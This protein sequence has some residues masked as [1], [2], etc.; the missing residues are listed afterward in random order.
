MGLK[1]PEPGL[2]LGN[3]GQ[4]G[5]EMKKNGMLMAKVFEK[6]AKEYGETFGYHSGRDFFVV[7]KNLDLI[8]SVLVKRFDCFT[9]RMKM[10]LISP[11]MSD[12]LLVA[13][14]IKWKYM[15][16]TLSP[17]FT[18]GKIKKMTATVCHKIDDV[19]KQLEKHAERGDCFDIF[20][21]YKGMTLD[22][23]AKVA[24]G[25]D[26][27]CIGDPKDS[28][29]AHT[30]EFFK[31]MPSPS[32]NPSMMLGVLFPEIGPLCSFW[33]SKTAKQG[34]AEAWLFDVLRRVIKERAA[35]HDQNIEYFDTLKLLLDQSQTADETGRYLTH[36]EIA[37]NCFV[38]LLA[39][40]ETTSTA[41][42]FSTWLLAKNEYKQDAL[43][44]ELKDNLSDRP[45]EEWYSTV[46]KLPYLD[47]VF[48]EA[49]R[50]FPPITFFVNRTCTEEC[51]IDGLTFEPGVQFGCT[52][53]GLT[54]EPG[55][56]FGVNVLGVH[57]DP[58]NW[59]EPEK[60]L[61]ERF[62]DNKTY[63]PMSWIPFGAGPR[64]CIGL[65]FAEME[66]KYALAKRFL[67][68]KT[69]HPMSWIP[70]GAGPR[71]CIGLRFAEMEYKYALAKVLLKY[72]I[73]FGPESEDPLT[74]LN[75]GVMQT[76]E[77]VTVR[78]E[79]R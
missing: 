19:L 20:T 17:T 30:R 50:M 11:A 68:N 48:H 74:V 76:T 31:D 38:F 12:S 63:H 67:D 34:K 54:F 28:F 60:F 23:I 57:F 44:Q 24:F 58:E 77:K 2:I 8:Q 43:A 36:H 9:D 13:E 10:P 37:N 16:S 72:K 6:W 7:S 65:R 26:T 46:M 55:V 51:T 73:V 49:T 4:L 66:Y 79:K 78:V 18:T 71:N 15:R 75:D 29:L 35:T 69:Y 1:G 64:N 70:F 62:L 3:L 22:V 27:N 61:P 53:D 5:V 59:S 52:I 56:Q 33:R 45:E 25:L 32:K 47:A 41:L 42:A 14:H 39:G 40:Y 21:T